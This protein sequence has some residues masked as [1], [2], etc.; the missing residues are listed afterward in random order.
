MGKKTTKP[1]SVSVT[2]TSKGDRGEI[3][4]IF[5]AAGGGVGSRTSTFTLTDLGKSASVKASGATKSKEEDKNIVRMSQKKEKKA[6][7]LND[8]DSHMPPQTATTTTLPS[9]GAKAIE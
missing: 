2:T 8:I 4:D 5:S 7:K 3:D 1:A 6:M 9:L